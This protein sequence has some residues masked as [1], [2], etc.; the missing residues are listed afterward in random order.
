MDAV[1]NSLSEIRGITQ[2][3]LKEMRLLVYELRP[4]TLE[5]EGLIGALQHRLDAVEGRT[6][7]KARLLLGEMVELSEHLEE[8]LYH[9]TQEALNNALK[10]AAATRVTV[11]LN[12]D[13]GQQVTLEITDNGSGFDQ[14]TLNGGGLGLVSMRERAEGLGGSITIASTPGKGTTVKVR[15]KN[16][17]I[18]NEPSRIF[19]SSHNFQ[20]SL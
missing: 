7:V 5:Q 14:D 15:V 12:V 16:E 4:A 1:D 19:L 10:H 8:A 20:E 9:I 17:E 6:G 13:E 11:R 3:A 2:Q 18:N